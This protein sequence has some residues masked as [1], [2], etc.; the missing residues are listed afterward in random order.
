MRYKNK[1]YIE[2]DV[3]YLKNLFFKMKKKKHSIEKAR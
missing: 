2:H 1:V 3:K